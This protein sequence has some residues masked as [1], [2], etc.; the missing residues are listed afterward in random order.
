[1]IIV[2]LA[3]SAT[4]NTIVVATT[5][6]RTAIVAA[7]RESASCVTRKN[8]GIVFNGPSVMK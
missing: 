8:A 4:N 6:L 1:V 3:M 7:V 5:V 2:P